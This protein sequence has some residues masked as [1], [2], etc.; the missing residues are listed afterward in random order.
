MYVLKQFESTRDGV[1]ILVILIHVVCLYHR[2]KKITNH[3]KQVWPLGSLAP[4]FWNNPHATKKCMLSSTNLPRLALE[5]NAIMQIIPKHMNERRRKESGELDVS[6]MPSP[7]S[8]SESDTSSYV[9]GDSPESEEAKSNKLEDYYNAGEPC[10]FWIQLFWYILCCDN[11]YHC[12]KC[13][14]SNK[15]LFYLFD[16]LGVP[17]FSVNPW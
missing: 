6:G 2:K 7:A 16:T 1:S 13:P 12:S 9:S 14:I 17:V 15:H 8:S 5:M 10:I 4:R 11:L 3:I